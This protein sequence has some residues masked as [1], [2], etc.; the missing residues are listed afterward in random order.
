MKRI[1]PPRSSRGTALVIGIVVSVVLT[2]LVTALFWVASAQ[3][4]V[5][6]GMAKMDQAFFGAEA[7]IQRVAWYHK[8]G[9]IDSITSPLIGSI[10]GYTYTVSWTTVALNTIR[11]DST[12]SL[13]KVSQNVHRNTLCARPHGLR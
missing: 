9:Q 8:N 10:N 7:G 6:A 3:V 2:G 11:I 5:T 4:E 13:G 12:G 1:R